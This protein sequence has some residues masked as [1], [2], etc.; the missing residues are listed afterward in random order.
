MPMIREPVRCEDEGFF[1]PDSI[2]WR[3]SGPTIVPAVICTGAYFFLNPWN[4]TIGIQNTTGRTDPLKRV[5]L[6]AEYM[7]A[8][9]FGDQATAQ[10]AAQV[11]NTIH[12]H[13]TGT[14]GPT[15]DRVHSASEPRNLLWLLI[16]YGQSA[17][18][19]YDAYGPRRLTVEERDRYWREES[20][21]VGELNRIPASMMPKSQA[22]ADTYLE[23]ERANLA[24]TEAARGVADLVFPPRV[25]GLIPHPAALP[26][27]VAASAGIALIPDYAMRLLGENPYPATLK[28]AI[29]IAHRPLFTALAATPGVR[30]AIPLSVSS[31][32]RALV[33]RARIAARTGDYDRPQRNSADRERL[34]VA[35]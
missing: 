27:Q 31:P 35:N 21:I 8:M 15:G 9:Y 12:D 25:A 28:A 2:S 11:V 32:L 22:D 18:D 4:A 29:R 23:G 14:W 20:A 6:T 1:G 19:A 13:V 17:L 16:P 7:F 5:V 34:W 26:L 3:I 33:R 24:M 30:D 10:H